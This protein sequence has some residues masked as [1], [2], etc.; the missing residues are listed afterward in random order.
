[1][2]ERQEAI[3]P[4]IV[5]LNADMADSNDVVA[6]E[7]ETNPELSAPPPFQVSFTFPLFSITIAV[8]Q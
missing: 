8:D 4:V 7:I 2:K 1:M 6:V 3:D 5:Q